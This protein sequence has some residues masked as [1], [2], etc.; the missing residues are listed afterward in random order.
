MN[1]RELLALFR[2]S[3]II[4]V[5]IFALAILNEFSV[6]MFYDSTDPYFVRFVT[7]VLAVVMMAIVIML[8]LWWIPDARKAILRM[9]G[10][11]EEPQ[12]KEEN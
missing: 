11:D 12:K 6:R 1:K 8:F 4:A 10:L 3:L 5:I 7:G 2:V 9:F